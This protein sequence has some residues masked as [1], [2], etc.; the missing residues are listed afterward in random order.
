MWW[1]H[2][3]GQ[4]V[5][6]TWRL[7]DHLNFAVDLALPSHTQQNMHKRL[8][9]ADTKNGSCINQRDE[10]GALQQGIQ[11]QTIKVQG[12]VH[13]YQDK[14]LQHHSESKT[15]VWSRTG[16]LQLPPR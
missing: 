8:S 15:T 12:H 13:N 7:I 10:Q 14:A 3:I 4:L 9:V 11:W 2:L 6:I 16:E 1:L 5:Q